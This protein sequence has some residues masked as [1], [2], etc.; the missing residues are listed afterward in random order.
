MKRPIE[1]LTVPFNPMPTDVE[2][3][4][5][6]LD[7]GELGEN[8][9]RGMASVF[10][11]PVEAYCPTI[12]MP[13]A[14]S[15]TIKERGGNIPILWQ[16]DMDEPIGKSVRL[17]E[18]EVGLVL[19]AKISRTTRGRD[20]LILLRDGT[21]NALSIGFEP[22]VFD[23]DEVNGTMTRYIR[24]VRLWETS[25][26]TLGADP[27]A[28]IFEV[29][30]LQ[31]GQFRGCLTGG[32]TPEHPITDDKVVARVIELAKAGELA[33]EQLSLI[34]E[35][36]GAEPV[37]EPLTPD[38]PSEEETFDVSGILVDAEL[39]AANLLLEME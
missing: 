35:A 26:V 22:I 14:F 15:K 13:G 27:S 18:N 39:L 20:A 37:D 12:M 34:R 38:E 10:G 16:H 9:F 2:P 36:L 24:E 21:V 30:S 32:R 4:D 1:F 5:D 8:E 33:T 29:N 3:E 19:Q 17:F 31:D 23:F 6:M 7:L 28:L 11:S 25:V